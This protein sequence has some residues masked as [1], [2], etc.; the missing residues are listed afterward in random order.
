MLL[1]R[2]RITKYS[3]EIRLSLEQFTHIKVASATRRYTYSIC[4]IKEKYYVME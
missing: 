3:T 1:K 2:K 4:C